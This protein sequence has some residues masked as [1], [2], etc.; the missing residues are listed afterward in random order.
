MA[1]Q[2]AAFLALPEATR[3]AVAGGARLAWA[4]RWRQRR[5]LRQANARRDPCVSGEPQS[6]RRWDAVRTRAQGLARRRS[7]GPRGG[8]VPGRERPQNRRQDRRAAETA[9]ARF[10]AQGSISPRTPTLTWARS[11]RACPRRR[12]A[13]RSPTRRS[14]RTPSLSS[15]GRT[16]RSSS[17]P[18]STRTRPRVRQSAASPSPIR[19]RR[20]PRS[21]ELRSPSPIHSSRSRSLRRGASAAA[22]STRPARPRRSATRRDR[23]RRGAGKA[24]TALK[25]NDCRIRLSPAS[26]CGSSA[27][28]PQ[29]AL[30]ILAG[31]FAS[32]GGAPRLGAPAQD[33][34]ILGFSGPRLAASSASFTGGEARR[35]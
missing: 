10:R 33:L 20:P 27:P 18:A 31:D 16:D 11:T 5:R 12:R 8:R 24:L 7:K 35:S 29:R 9:A 34:V 28:T 21:T 3:K 6:A 26:R 2:K 25:T 13:A 1:A 4:L 23:A 32:N 22:P 14:S 30:A 15:R 19:R 17:I